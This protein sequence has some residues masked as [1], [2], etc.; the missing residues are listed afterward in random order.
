MHLIAIRKTLLA[1]Y[2]SL[3]LDICRA[4]NSAKAESQSRLLDLDALAVVLPWVVAEAEETEQL[5]GKD[6]W[7]YGI[8]KN[9]L[10]IEAQAR[11]SFEQGL[12]SRLLS[13]DELFE[14]STLGWD[15]Q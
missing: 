5:M 1:E 3:A 13:A 9:R 14:R 7:P 12:S 2:P 4:F 11:W 8:V 10:M 6:Y 15:P